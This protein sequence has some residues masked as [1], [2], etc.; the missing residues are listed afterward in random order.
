MFSRLAKNRSSVREHI[1]RFLS[2]SPSRFWL[3]SGCTL[4]RQPARDTS[5]LPYRALPTEGQINPKMCFKVLARAENR[6]DDPG[7]IH[8]LLSRSLFFWLPRSTSVSSRPHFLPSTTTGHLIG[9]MVVPL[10][11][12]L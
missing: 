10:S 8:R 9:S 7:C 4:H 1:H 11:C 5:S 6:S 2:L 12:W 3:A